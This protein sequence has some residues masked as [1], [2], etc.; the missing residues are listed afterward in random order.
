[1]DINQTE[2]PQKEGS[3]ISKFLKVL[4]PLALGVVVLWLLYRDTDFGK[5]WIT[6]KDANFAILLFSLIFGALGN[7]IRG[8]RWKLLIEPLGYNPPAS[9]LIYAVLGSYAVNIAIP[10]GGEVWR[11]AVVAKD[12]KIPFAKLFGTMILD[13]VSDT[14]TVACIILLACCFNVE[15]FLSY[16]KENAALS[17]SLTNIFSSGW[18]IG[19][20]IAA[21]VL[22]VVIYK[23]FKNTTPIIKLTNLFKGLGRDMQTVFKMKRKGR[24]LL[25]T[26]GIWFSYFLYFYIT[27]YAFDFTK[28]L[29][30]T[31]GLI[32][33]A[34]SSLSMAIPTN[35]GMGVWHAAVVLS[36]GLYGVTKDSGEAFAF[37]VFA[38][39]SLWIVL[40]GLFSMGA[41]TIKNR[42]K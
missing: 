34:L 10:R 39:Q 13:R 17:N 28:D 38:I 31:A 26:I 4:I 32:A 5:M 24:F 21:I 37:A 12:E 35:G 1:M 20:V 19:G 16:I 14:V 25:Y 27:F 40:C 41:L 15:F 9:S 11:C 42:N 6:I 2:E 3:V 18:M 8:L 36:L 7:V 33:F 29:G 23:L 22:I 30:L